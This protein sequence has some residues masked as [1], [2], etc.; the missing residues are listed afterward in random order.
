[1]SRGIRL[2]KGLAIAIS[3]LTIAYFLSAGR[4]QTV[5]TYLTASNYSLDGVIYFFIISALAN[6]YIGIRGLAFNILWHVPLFI[7]VLMVAL[8]ATRNDI[9]FVSL[10]VY[11]LAFVYLGIDCYQ[12]WKYGVLRYN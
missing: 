5:I 1:M 6:L 7:I 10:S 2:I 4:L 12:D 3:Y 8:A 9:N 11:G